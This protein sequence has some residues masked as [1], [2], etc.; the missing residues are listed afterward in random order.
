M[1]DATRDS[2]KREVRTPRDAVVGW[3]IGGVNTKAA[4]V[5]DGRILAVQGRPYELQ[6]APTELSSKL[7]DLSE[8]LSA[9]DAGAH[10]ITMTAELSQIFRTKREGVW[11]V[12]D[13]C[14]T[15]FPSSSLNVYTV[16][17]RFL[18]TAAAR[19]EPLAVAAANWSATARVVAELHP[20]ALLVDTG[21]TTTDV[22]PIVAGA[23]VA[24]GRTDPERLSS[25][26]LVYSGALRTPTEA[27]ASHVEIGGRMVG[28]SAEG[29]ALAG[30]VHLWRGDLAP[31]DYTVPTPDGRPATR[32]FA[33]ERLARVVCA[34][35]DLLD[36]AQITAIA[37]SLA[38]AQVARIVDAMHRVIASHPSITM[39][40]VTGLGAFL[41]ASAAGRLGL[42]VAP[43]E[44]E[45]GAPAARFAPAAAVALLFER[46]RGRG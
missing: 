10:A 37:N 18:T 41:G 2:M 19:E 14:E 8:D 16:D 28:V 21:T 3:D 39:A 11:F 9:A 4:C 13:A 35:R 12:L 29:F 33:G 20:D 30:D 7:R 17:G 22:I 46:W 23:V 32:E 27:M 24:S 5:S 44:T 45:L 42:R 26:E 1:A 6:Q 15:A 40:C 36:E 25:G 38:E 43:L 34:D 31:V